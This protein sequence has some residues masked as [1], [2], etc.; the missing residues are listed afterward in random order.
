MA[1]RRRSHPIALGSLLEKVY[2]APSQLAEARIFAFWSKSMPP[3]IMERA[4]PVRL[5]RGVLYV[6]CISSVWAQELHHMSTE[7]LQRIRAYEP[8][9]RVDA[10]RFKVGPLPDV[11]APRRPRRDDTRPIQTKALPE[12]LGRALA[13][14]PDDELRMLI[15]RAAS[16]ALGRD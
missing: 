11:V 4:R 15:A 6:N 13:R 9:A 8:K 1:R 2:P 5:H 10:L 7:L 14:V 16:T 3:R 12:E